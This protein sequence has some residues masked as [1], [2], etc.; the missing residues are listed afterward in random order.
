MTKKSLC[1]IYT[2]VFIVMLVS[3]YLSLQEL[4][5]LPLEGEENLSSPLPVLFIILYF[6]LPMF[7]FFL[8]LMAM[9]FGLPMAGIEM[10]TCWIETR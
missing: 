1:V 4:P 3:G 6:V 8:V 9:L 7:L 10:V 5:Q 2:I